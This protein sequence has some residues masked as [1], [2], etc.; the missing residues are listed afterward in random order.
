MR[1]ILITGGTGFIGS[2]FVYKFLELGD[3]INLIV[4]PK[5]NF[6]RIESIKNK[7]KLHKID[8]SNAEELE[9]FI[10]NL[11]PEIILHFATYGAYQGRQQDIKAT[12]DTNLLGTI[13]LVNACSKTDFECFINTGSSSEYGIK[14]KPMKETDL[15]EPDNLYGITKAA[16]TMYCQYMAKK[17]NLPIVTFRLFSVYGYFEEKKRLIPT[18]IKSCLEN[19]KLKLSSA[20]SVRD[21]IFIEDIIDAYLKAINNIQKIQGEIFNLGTGKQTEIAQVVKLVKEITQSKVKPEYNQIKS[22]QI[23]PKTWVADTSKTKKLLNWHSKYNLKNGLERDIDWF[24]KNIYV[25][26]E[27]Q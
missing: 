3:E 21:F 1:K 25:Y 13:N 19:K 17:H 18:I 7:L 6:W 24:K 5:S 12:I 27:K 26:E 15:L 8:L 14:N 9:R 11:K 20:N 22:V 4:R 16:A 23:E 2:N 10:S